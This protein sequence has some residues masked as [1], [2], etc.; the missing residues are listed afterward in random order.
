MKAKSRFPIIGILALAFFQ[1]L[2]FCA[3]DERIGE[4]VFVSGQDG[5]HTCRIP[6]LAV[7]TQGTVLAFCEGRKKGGGD[8][9]D[10]NLPMKHSADHGRTWSA[11]QV[12]RVL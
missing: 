7:K 11:Q 12:N 3:A 1:S 8:S 5:Y 6:A 10:I 9:G 4:P 2:E